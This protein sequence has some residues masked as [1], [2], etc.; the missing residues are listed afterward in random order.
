MFNRKTKR[1]LIIIWGIY[2]SLLNCWA[3]NELSV[4][5]YER[6]FLALSHGIHNIK[7][8]G[9]EQEQYLTYLNEKL[10]AME[11]HQVEIKITGDNLFGSQN[12]LHIKAIPPKTMFDKLFFQERTPIE[13][14]Y[15]YIN[16]M[17]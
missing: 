10:T 13:F 17:R 12:T 9:L 11:F 14:S 6:E 5:P 3:I 16:M 7:A 2:F 15:T 1:A 4:F 8:N